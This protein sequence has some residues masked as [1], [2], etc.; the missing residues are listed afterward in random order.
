MG[1]LDRDRFEPL[2]VLPAEGPLRERLGA[3]GCATE[4][5]PLAWWIPASN[6]SREEFLAQLAGLPQRVEGLRTMAS[7]WGAEIVHTNT[8]VTIEGALAAAQLGLPH[9]WHLRAPFWAG[10]FPPPYFDHVT[11]FFHAVDQLSDRVLCVSRTVERQIPADCRLAPRSVLLDGVD[12]GDAPAPPA[13]SRDALARRYGIEATSRIVACVGGIQQNKGQI[14]L[15][16]A[17]GPLA[18]RF[19]SV[20]FVLCGEADREYGAMV[21][22]RIAALGLA[23]RFRLPGFEKDVRSLLT[24]AELLVHPARA[25]GFGLAILEAMAAGKPVVATRSGGPEE[26]VEDGV[27][28]LLVPAADP[29]ALGAALGRV[30]GDAA[31]ASA[32]A[33]GAR[34][35]ARRFTLAASARKTEE[36]YDGLLASDRGADARRSRQSR[37]ESVLAELLSLA[38]AAAR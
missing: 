5:A 13:E 25:E 10:R 2:V 37:A 33:R 1:A 29:P 23:S 22:A 4:V 28:G 8:V 9:V 31:L 19:P 24:H 20:V 30:L 17:A 27:S 34:R 32:L 16:E 6:W 38:A 14:D 35:R 15:V 11:F 12:D 3:S 26:I 36:V 7:R 21:R 18:S